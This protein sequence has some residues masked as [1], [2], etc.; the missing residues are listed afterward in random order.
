MAL[1][2][3]HLK[4][5][6]AAPPS[7]TTSPTI[8]TL[9]TAPTIPSHSPPPPPP[10]P[11]PAPNIPPS[12][13][14]SDTNFAS[15]TALQP[16]SRGG[17]FKFVVKGAKA[18]MNGMVKRLSETANDKYRFELMKSMSDVSGSF[19]MTEFGFDLRRPSFLLDTSFSSGSSVDSKTSMSVD[20]DRFLPLRRDASPSLLLTSGPNP[21]SRCRSNYVR[22][23]KMSTLSSNRSDP[24]KKNP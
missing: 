8:P 11:P 24:K 16:K 9:S 18:V 19:N 12:F 3:T 17:S 5:T 22:A 21:Q 15:S 13:G 23:L 20:D 7:L 1:P 6:T 14:V 4:G 10:Q 2:P